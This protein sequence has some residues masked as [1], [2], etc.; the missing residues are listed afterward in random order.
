M[1]DGWLSPQL[2]PTDRLFA[3]DPLRSKL[4]E[5]M[6]GETLVPFQDGGLCKL[7]GT[8]DLLTDKETV[9]IKHIIDFKEGLAELLLASTAFPGKSKKLV[10]FSVGK[11]SSMWWVWW[12]HTLKPV[13]DN[14]G[15]SL[16]FRTVEWESPFRH[17]SGGCTTIGVPPMGGSNGGPQEGS[18]HLL[19]NLC[20][21]VFMVATS[22]SLTLYIMTFYKEEGPMSMLHLVG[23]GV[24]L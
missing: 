9:I 12:E 22:I 20:R 17:G 11:K 2:D 16:V 10:L 4:Q 15:I 24:E 19:F 5:E 1:T 13:C 6:G 7:N 14:C 8:V 3:V 21:C 23:P 18:T